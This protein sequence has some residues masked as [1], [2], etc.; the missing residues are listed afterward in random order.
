MPE[1]SLEVSLYGTVI[2]ELVR[3]R[4]GADFR[5]SDAA[6][7]RWGLNSAVLSRSL[8]VGT[9]NRGQ[10]ESFFG[11]LL[12]E[13]MHLDRLAKE[14]KVA[15][16]DLVGLLEH[17][18]AD[19]A[20]ALRIGRPRDATEPDRLSER[21]VS[22]L[23]DTA[24]GFLVGGGG[25]AL[26][27]FQRK[28]TLTRRDGSWWRGNG[29][30]ASTHILKPVLTE[31]RSAVEGE[32]YLLAIGRELGLVTYES[33]T[34]RI[35][36]RFVLVVERYDRRQ[37]G[38]DIVR[39]HQED[40]G[41]A[42]GLPWGGS[43]KFEQN[44]SRASLVSVAG[45]LDT[46]RT[47]FSPGRPDAEKLLRYTVLTVAGGNTDAHAKNFSLLHADDGSTELA[48]YYD[49]APLAL[50]YDGTQTLAMRVNGVSQLPDVTRDDLVEEAAGWGLADARP[51]V[52]ETLEAIIAATRSLEAHAS[53][54]AH[55]PGYVRGQAQNLLD[56]R[57]ARI[58]SA[59]PLLTLEHLGS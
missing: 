39:L 51:I 48:P 58:P 1:E 12:P 54:A 23:L 11:A 41:Q 40:T 36:D 27:G 31:H 4:G 3:G 56:G 30:I 38:D 32:A 26:P 18:G 53:I 10:A 42:L 2:G 15:S 33:W 13:G 46:G 52:D 21:E 14:A 19:L 50:A 5:W 47:V 17:V 9:T 29:S 43:E 55:V 25:T 35:G 45:L 8:L 6:E 44:D 28:L 16:D 20:G 24:S 57:P 49:A 7:R 22:L 59:V 34:E 37:Q